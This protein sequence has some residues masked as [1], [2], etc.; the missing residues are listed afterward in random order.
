MNCD[1]KFRVIAL[2][3]KL[4]IVIGLVLCLQ[5]IIRRISSH[6]GDLGLLFHGAIFFSRSSCLKDDLVSV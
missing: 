4:V 6:K 5:R 1:Y 2:I 3:R